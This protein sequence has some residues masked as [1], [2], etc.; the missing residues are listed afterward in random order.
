M[1]LQS[2]ELCLAT[3]KERVKTLPWLLC[4]L[5]ILISTG[6]SSYFQSRITIPCN[7]TDVNK[8]HKLD[9][10]CLP[11]YLFT[12]YFK[13]EDVPMRLN[14]LKKDLAKL[15]DNPS[16]YLAKC[17]ASDVGYELL[18]FRKELLSKAVASIASSPLR[19]HPNAPYAQGVL[20][21]IL[22]VIHGFEAELPIYQNRIW[23]NA[24]AEKLCPEWRQQFIEI[25]VFGIYVGMKQLLETSEEGAHYRSC[26]HCQTIIKEESEKSETAQ[27]YHAHLNRDLVGS[28]PP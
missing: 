28:T 12:S 7:H 6:F 26:T 24:I 5:P 13:K 21:G 23:L 27:H 17:I 20:D 14:K 18:R 19:R 15:H 1:T 9:K 16:D 10:S 4:T 25:M 2:S 22:E 11:C 8:T 3:P